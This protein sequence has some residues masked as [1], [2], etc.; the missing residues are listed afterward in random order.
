MAS[1]GDLTLFISLSIVLAASSKP[2]HANSPSLL[3]HG[4]DLFLFAVAHRKLFDFRNGLLY[5]FPLYFFEKTK[6]RQKINALQKC[7]F[8]L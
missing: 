4:N 5:L 6:R 3:P 1:L 2:L 7:V 8:K